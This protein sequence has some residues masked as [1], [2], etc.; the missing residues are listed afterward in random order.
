MVL[1][2]Y[3]KNM[4]LDRHQILKTSAKNPIMDVVIL[5]NPNYFKEKVNSSN[6]FQHTDDDFKIDDSAPKFIPKNK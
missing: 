2:S 6:L 3:E 4:P 5:K 1:L